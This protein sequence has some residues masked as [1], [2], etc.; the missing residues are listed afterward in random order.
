[1]A[2][3]DKE[4]TFFDHLE[5]LRWHIIRSVIAVFVLMVAAFALKKIIF[6]QILFGPTKPDFA[7][8]EFLC[9]LSSTIK[10]GSAFC[11]EQV[12]YKIVNLE[13]AGQFMVHLKTSLAVGLVLAFPYIFWEMWRFIT[14]GLHDDELKKS[15]F[16][17]LAGSVLFFVGVLFGYFVL[18]PFSITFF[19]NYNVSDTIKNTFGL[20]NY[21]NFLVMLVV[22]TGIMFELPMVVFF[23]AKLGIVTPQMMRQ[24]R[25]HALI[26]IMIISAIITPADIGTMVMVTLP[27]M[28]LYEISIFIAARIYKQRLKRE[29]EEQ[30]L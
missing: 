20:S 9:R 27:V 18:S 11:I 19:A 7:T 2:R 10:F 12:N 3:T 8:Y 24:Y 28:L 4:M 23:L 30:N 14:P 17:I 25:K 26:V 22:A 13:M 16:A 29:F 5:E 21:I 1:M 6:G 15:R